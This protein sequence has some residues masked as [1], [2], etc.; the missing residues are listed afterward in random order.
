MAFWL[1]SLVACAR[2]VGLCLFP[3][4]TWVRVVGRCC[5]FA[6][7]GLWNIYFVVCEDCAQYVGVWLF[8]VYQVLSVS[9]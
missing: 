4:V 6:C 3:L 2:V 1:L 5:H 8:F 7:P 9:G